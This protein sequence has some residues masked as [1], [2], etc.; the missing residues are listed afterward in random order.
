MRVNRTAIENAAAFDRKYGGRTMPDDVIPVWGPR[1]RKR[2]E[3]A[4]HTPK[5]VLRDRV[6]RVK[7]T[8]LLQ[9]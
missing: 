6:M 5:R 3:P 1:K 7:L 2:P 9:E 4:K 8:N